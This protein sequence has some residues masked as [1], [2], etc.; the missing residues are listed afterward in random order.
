MIMNKLKLFKYVF[1]YHI[2]EILQPSNIPY[3]TEKKAPQ[4]LKDF[5]KISEKKNKK[6]HRPSKKKKNRCAFEGC[7]KKLKLTDMDCKCKNRFCSLHRLPETH[8]CSWDPKS[9]NEMNI[10][11][12]KSGLN[13][14]SAFAKMERI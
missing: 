3:F 5:S 11:K 10:Y 12:E 6:P 14:V 9:E 13:Q 1:L 7:R 2:M 4:P 8:N